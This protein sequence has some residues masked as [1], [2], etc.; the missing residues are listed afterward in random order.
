MTGSY[1]M[2]LLH[3]SLLN[4]KI[5]IIIICDLYAFFASVFRFSLKKRVKSVVRG[6]CNRL[7]GACSVLRIHLKARYVNRELLLLSK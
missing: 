3:V 2:F 1:S 5:I 6:H 4:K 7:N